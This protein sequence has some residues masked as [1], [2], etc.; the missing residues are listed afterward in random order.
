LKKPESYG[1]LKMCTERRGYGR[2]YY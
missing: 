1:N 2:G